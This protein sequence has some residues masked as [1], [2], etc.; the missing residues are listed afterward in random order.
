MSDFLDR[1][2][3]AISKDRSG[4]DRSPTPSDHSSPPTG[5]T[6][7]HPSSDSVGNNSRMQRIL[8][9]DNPNGIVSRWRAVLIG[10]LAAG[11]GMAIGHLVAS[12]KRASA[13]PVLAVGEAV[14]DRTPTGLKDFAIKQFGTNDKLV[15]LLSVS[16]GALILAGLAGLLARKIFLAGLGLELF[17]VTIAGYAAMTRP[18]AVGSD[19][20]PTLATASVGV[21]TLFGLFWLSGDAYTRNLVDKVLTR[22]QTTDGRQPALASTRRVFLAGSGAVAALAVASGVVGQKLGAVTS[23]VKLALPSAKKKAPQIPV[24]LTAKYPGITALRTPNENFYRVDTS[25]TVPNINRDDWRLQIGGDVDKKLTL[26][27]D[28]ISKM[29]LIERNISLTC[30]SNEPGGS[31]AGGATWL[32]VRVKDLLDMAGIK[33]PQKKGRQLFSESSEGFSISTPLSAMLDDRDALLAIGMNGKALPRAHGFPARLVTPGLYGMLG[34]TKWVTRLTVTDYDQKTAYWTKRGWTKDGPIKPS[35]RI[36]TPSDFGTCKKTADGKQIIGGIAWAQ[37]EGVVKV[38][39]S[40]DEGPWKDATMGPDVNVDY[41]RQWVYLWDTK[42]KGQHQV[43]AR[44]VYGKDSLQSTTRK[45]V[46]PNGSSGIV[47]L[48]FSVD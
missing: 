11:L 30:I 18:A 19:I 9:P 25:L 33:D 3:S 6:P 45:D 35:A 4:R 46:F 1:M 21:I 23:T 40:I 24:G 28:D 42:A 37:G 22:G 39:V 38:Q 31:Y 17:L 15:L 44:I 34:C 2:R 12:F 48:F 43:R 41:W 14:I 13:S 8:H 20:V 26:S 47:N 16:A 10:I 29:D 36:D 5:A 27:Y 32:G 7:V